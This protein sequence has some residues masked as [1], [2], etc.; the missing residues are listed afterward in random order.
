MTAGTTTLRATRDEARINE[1]LDRVREKLGAVPRAYESIATSQG[2]LS[3]TMYN[4][5]KV[6]VDG[7]LD[8]ATKHLIAVAVALVCGGHNIVT[9][10]IEEA[11]ADGVSD[12]FITEAL[13]VAA[14]ITQYNTFY[15]FQHLAG[16]GFDGLKPGFKLS[17]FLR[18]AHIALVQVELICAM[19][20]TVNNCPSCVRGHV[21]KSMQ[22][23]ATREQIEEGLR[24][25]A[26]MAGFA[27]FTKID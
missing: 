20:S 19:V 8:L 13:T 22:H 18:P 25:A 11:R 4:L 14:S 26:L 12:D 5:K 16:E 3:D 10:C 9:A 17:T 21:S 23:G 1:L 15:K 7:E 27:T 6:M 24:V 2:F